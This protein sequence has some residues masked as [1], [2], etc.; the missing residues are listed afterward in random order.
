M[1][2]SATDLSGNK[3]LDTHNLY[4]TQQVMASNNWDMKKG[5]RTFVL[6]RSGFSG[7]GKFG[8]T[9][10]GE[11]FSTDQSMAASVT[12][13]MM[14]NILGQPL[15]GADICGYYGNGGGDQCI[16]WYMVGAF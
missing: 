14:S 1:A 10:F 16:R 12:A 2:I 7:I 8:Q 3:Q 4:S 6:S 13:T 15:S 11:N 5:S 9:Y